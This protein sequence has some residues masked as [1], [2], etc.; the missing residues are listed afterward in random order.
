VLFGEI[1]TD[2]GHKLWSC[3]PSLELIEEGVS[4]CDCQEK[5]LCDYQIL[6]REQAKKNFLHKRIFFKS[7]Q[8]AFEQH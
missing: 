1:G 6:S 5:R 4:A 7:T 3:R 8:L 2:F